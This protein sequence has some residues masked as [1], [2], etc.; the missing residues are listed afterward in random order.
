M[1]KTDA[2]RDNIAQEIYPHRRRKKLPV[3]APH[4]LGGTIGI[5]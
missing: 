5:Y 2:T 1:G 3:D 4:V